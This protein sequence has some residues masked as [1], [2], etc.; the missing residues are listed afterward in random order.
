MII[1][2]CWRYLWCTH[3][4]TWTTPYYFCANSAVLCCHFL[5]LSRSMLDVSTACLCYIYYHRFQWSATSK[6]SRQWFAHYCWGTS[7][8]WNN[9]MWRH[10]SLYHMIDTP[11]KQ[12]A[13]HGLESLLVVLHRNRWLKTGFIAKDWLIFFIQTQKVCYLPLNAFIIKPSQRLL[14][15]KFLLE[16]MSSQTIYSINTLITQPSLRVKFIYS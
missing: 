10:V 1:K 3:C 7:I 15:Y 12:C 6:N 2:K 16:S 14:H 9:E 11:Q 13:N 5:S 8:M 4:F